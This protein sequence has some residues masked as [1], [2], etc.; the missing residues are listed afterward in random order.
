MEGICKLIIS[1]CNYI[2]DN[3]IQLLN[4]QFYWLGALLG[5]LGTEKSWLSH[6]KTQERFIQDS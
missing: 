3:D 2:H 6:E 4:W 1:V 5:N